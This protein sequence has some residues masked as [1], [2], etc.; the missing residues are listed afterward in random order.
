MKALRGEKDGDGMEGQLE[1]DQREQSPVRAGRWP[2]GHAVPTGV[3]SC[4]CT[5]AGGS[6]P[7][8]VPGTESP[9]RKDARLPFLGKKALTLERDFPAR[10]P[11]TEQGWTQE[12][13]GRK[14]ALEAAPGQ[15]GCRS[16]PGP[17]ESP[18]ATCLPRVLRCAFW[19]LDCGLGP[20]GLAAPPGGC[21]SAC[22][23]TTAGTWRSRGTLCLSPGLGGPA[24][25]VAGIPSILWPSGASLQTRPVVSGSA[26]SWMARNSA[27]S[28][29][30]NP[31][32]SVPGPV[33]GWGAHARTG[34][35]THA[36]T[37]SVLTLHL[38]FSTI[39]S[40]Q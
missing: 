14:A 23:C 30:P 11:Q 9:L 16:V 25:L 40:L 15:E 37:V 38:E 13:V 21:V 36:H 6:V 31:R 20:V 27:R 8:H 10:P 26:F 19:Q 29:A 24:A 35:H 33:P 7:R 5:V 4:V 32:D 17:G 1:P 2:G 3:T 22:T 39:E 12:A 34:T 18:G 28:A